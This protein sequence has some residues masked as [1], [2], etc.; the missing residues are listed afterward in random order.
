MKVGVPALVLI[1]AALLPGP[2]SSAA[3]A[4]AS[5]DRAK[6]VCSGSAWTLIGPGWRVPSVQSFAAS[7]G[8]T[9]PSAAKQSRLLPGVQYWVLLT[10]NFVDTCA[11]ARTV[12]I[13]VGRNSVNGTYLL[14]I[15]VQPL[16]SGFSAPLPRF[17]ARPPGAHCG[18][19]RAGAHTGRVVRP[20]QFRADLPDYASIRQALRG[21]LVTS[22]WQDVRDHLYR[23][24]F[25]GAGGSGPNKGH[26]MIEVI[27]SHACAG[28][29][30]PTTVDTTTQR[31]GPLTL[32]S[33]RGTAAY[34]TFAGGSG[35]LYLRSHRF[36]M[37]RGPK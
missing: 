24:V 33:V 27:V 31:T 22:G 30:G 36:V 14:A 29:I 21:F 17:P 19:A 37:T 4:S 25:A 23:T 11:R 35:V 13:E 3:G 32:T 18:P 12:S 5:A 15:S 2:P 7:G 10:P 16:A 8:K 6:L 26:G 28:Q 34:F 20:R 1:I 9:V